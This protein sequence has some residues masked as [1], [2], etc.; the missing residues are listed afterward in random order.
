MFNEPYIGTEYWTIGTNG[1]GY[2]SVSSLEDAVINHIREENHC[3]LDGE[4]GHGPIK[5]IKIVRREMREEVFHLSEYK[6]ISDNV[7]DLIGE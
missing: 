5:D 4:L 3:Q 6:K 1:T 7:A 2:C